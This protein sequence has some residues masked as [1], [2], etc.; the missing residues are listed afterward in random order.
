MPAYKA[1]A[2]REASLS[3][4]EA[5]RLGFEFAIKMAGV[6]ERWVA[7]ASNSSSSRIRWKRS[8][9][10]V[11][12]IQEDPDEAALESDIIETFKLGPS[13]LTTPKSKKRNRM[14]L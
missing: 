4:E 3:V 11:D 14:S 12:A 8:N 7:L 9:A 2:K 10:G 1:L 6:R 5:N 13:Q